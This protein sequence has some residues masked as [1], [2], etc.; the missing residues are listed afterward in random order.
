MA[1]AYR[2]KEI[3]MNAIE[4]L[5]QEHVKAKTEFARVL[6][7]LADEREDLWARN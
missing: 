5:K 2:E 1:N 7:A 3:G 6:G 4:W